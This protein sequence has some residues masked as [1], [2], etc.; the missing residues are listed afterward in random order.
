ML[1]AGFFFFSFSHVRFLSPTVLD[2][3]SDPSQRLSHSPPLFLLMH[4]SLSCP[5]CISLQEPFCPC[6]MVRIFYCLILSLT[7]S[8]RNTHRNTYPN[9]PHPFYNTIYTP[10]LSLT[11]WIPSG[12]LRMAFMWATTTLRFSS[13]RCKILLFV[14]VIKGQTISTQRR[15][16]GI[17]K[18]YS[19]YQYHPI[20]VVINVF[21]S[22]CL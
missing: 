4:A 19:Q 21:F 1:L 12:A 9:P 10:L 16:N 18:E 3:L 14:K 22:G 8:H 20:N 6:V 17:K 7:H 13:K 11:A 5:I 15:C 2:D